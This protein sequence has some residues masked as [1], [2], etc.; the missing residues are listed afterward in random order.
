MSERI[1]RHLKTLKRLHHMKS[2]DRHKLLQSGGREII[3]CVCECA[4]NVLKGTVPLKPNHLKKLRRW[5]KNLRTLALKRPSLKCKKKIIQNGGFI[6]A[7]LP[8]V[9][10]FLGSLL[11]NR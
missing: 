8:P 5:K 10:T 9:L 7:L 11:F 4:K 6:G 1:C 3:E 2:K